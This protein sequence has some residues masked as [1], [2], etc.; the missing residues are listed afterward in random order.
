M[1][2]C[3]TN[4]RKSKKYELKYQNKFQKIGEIQEMSNKN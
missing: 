1:P 3:V 4:P 2:R